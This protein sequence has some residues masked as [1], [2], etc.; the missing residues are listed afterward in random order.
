MC[1]C[2]EVLRLCV[3][4]LSRFLSHLGE[5]GDGSHTQR[6]RK[7]LGDTQAVEAGAGMVGP[8]I[9]VVRVSCL[10]CVTERG[11][12]V[13][14]IERGLVRGRAERGPLK[15]RAQDT[16]SSYLSLIVIL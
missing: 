3:Q 16:G 1:I 7:L 12:R 4:A 9:A 5:G 14:C 6:C 11:A 15:C 10:Q 13:K 2:V 8:K